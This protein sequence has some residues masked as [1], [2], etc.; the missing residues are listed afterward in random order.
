MADYS[1]ATSTQREFD[2]D[3]LEAQQE[4]DADYLEWLVEFLGDRLPAPVVPG[5]QVYESNR[6][7]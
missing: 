6:T 5:E 1:K 7:G 2:E 4:V 3:E